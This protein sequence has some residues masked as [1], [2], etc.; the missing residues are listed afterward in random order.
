M[1][2]KLFEWEIAGQS[3]WGSIKEFKWMI[4]LYVV[5]IFLLSN[6]PLI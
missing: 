2:K 1:P 5:D 3:K 4:N 6:I